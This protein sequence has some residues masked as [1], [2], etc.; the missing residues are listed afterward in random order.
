MEKD[1]IDK[2]KIK[3]LI[4]FSQLTEI[5]SGLPEKENSKIGERGIKLSGVSNKD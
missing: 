3:K 2:N 5:V 1:Q 4:D